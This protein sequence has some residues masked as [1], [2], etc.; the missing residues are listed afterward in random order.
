MKR[1]MK[2]LDIFVVTCIA[3]FMLLFQGCAIGAPKATVEPVQLKGVVIDSETKTPLVAVEVHLLWHEKSSVISNMMPTMEDLRI[4]RR[5]RSLV[6]KTST[7]GDFVLNADTVLNAQDVRME[8]YA[9]QFTKCGYEPV[10]LPIGSAHFPAMIGSKRF[11]EL[12]RAN[13]T[14]LFHVKKCDGSKIIYPPVYKTQ[15]E[16]LLAIIDTIVT[17][18]DRCNALI[19]TLLS[20]GVDDLVN[21]LLQNDI[22]PSCSRE[23]GVTPLMLAAGNSNFAT[24]KVV[25]AKQNN[26]NA[27]TNTGATALMYAASAK[28]SSHVQLLLSKGAN[29]KLKDNRGDTALSMARQQLD[30]AS[31]KLLEPLQ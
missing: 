24:L 23:D 20:Y 4:P 14:S 19:E 11:V 1:T 5:G 31:V 25:I 16:L 30:N 15:R 18:E 17:P 9:A 7:D 10:Q 27:A 29:A 3:S 2:L 12:R 26:I 21:G 8:N 13:S 22:G 6:A 28:L